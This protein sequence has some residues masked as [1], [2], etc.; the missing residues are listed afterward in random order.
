MK[1]DNATII[2][3]ISKEDGL[4]GYKS[5][6]KDHM[7]N[8]SYI[9]GHKCNLD[10]DF[11]RKKIKGKFCVT[12]STTAKEMSKE[13]CN[14]LP[15]SE[16]IFPFWGRLCTFYIASKRLHRDVHDV[17]RIALK[18]AKKWNKDKN[19]MSK[20]I[21]EVYIC[22]GSQIYKESLNNGFV[23]K[24]IITYIPN[25]YRVPQY[26]GDTPIYFPEI[27]SKYWTQTGEQNLGEDVIVKYYTR[28]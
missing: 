18:D 25:K 14:E 19:F 12:S 15:I 3:G 4:I 20:D 9:L 23:N 8:D 27:Y 13:F 7:G 17:I 16:H 1:L 5:T 10:K 2:A 21:K 28:K 22:G 6:F 11:F 26:P 24:M